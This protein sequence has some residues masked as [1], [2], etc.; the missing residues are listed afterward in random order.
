M[1][2]EAVW[3][4][5]PGL[6]LPVPRRAAPIATMANCSAIAGTIHRRYWTAWLVVPS[7]ALISACVRGAQ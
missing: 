5:I 7:S 3:T 4:I 6:K 2:T 1:I